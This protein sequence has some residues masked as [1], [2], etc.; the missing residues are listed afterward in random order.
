MTRMRALSLALVA[1]AAV[2]APVAESLAQT[3]IAVVNVRRLL[4]EAP[5]AKQAMQILQNEFAAREKEIVQIQTSLK[6]KDE[7][8]QRD[9]ATMTETDRRNA[10]RD[11][12][13]SQRDLQRKQQEFAEDYNLRRNEEIGKVQRSLLQEVQTYAKTNNFDLV[14]GDGVLY[15]SESIDITP[16]VLS[17]LQARQKSGAAAPKPATP[18]PKP[19]TPANKQ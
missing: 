13:D 7:K 5:Q 17:A 19:A 6:G 15:A 12:R 18:A 1:S 16:Q 10:E 11:L 3:K 2:L 4:E 9:G 8:F 14:V